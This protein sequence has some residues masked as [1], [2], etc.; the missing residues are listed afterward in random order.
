MLGIDYSPES[1]YGVLEGNE[2]EMKKVVIGIVVVV[3]IALVVGFVPIMEVPYT[4]QHQHTE[5]FYE[6]G[7]PKE[8]LVIRFETHYERV[9]IFEYLLSRF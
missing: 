5:A 3:A 1:L 4:V 2:G 6:N 9:P 8:R 7:Q